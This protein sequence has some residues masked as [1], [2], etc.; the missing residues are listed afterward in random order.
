MTTPSLDSILPDYADALQ[1]LAEFPQIAANLSSNSP[2]TEQPKTTHE[3]FAPF[4]LAVLSHR[5]RTP[6]LAI[7]RLVGRLCTG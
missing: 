2:L 6:S 3:D 4:V 5:D 7:S 1:R